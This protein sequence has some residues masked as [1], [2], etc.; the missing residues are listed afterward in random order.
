[1][2][3]EAFQEEGGGGGGMLCFVALFSETACKVGWKRMLLLIQFCETRFFC[4][5]GWGFTTADI[6]PEK[7]ELLLTFLP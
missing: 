4:W 1:M 2:Y 5:G 6:V 3:N 7:N